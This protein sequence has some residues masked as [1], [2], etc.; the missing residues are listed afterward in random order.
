MKKKEN[1]HLAEGE[2]T[3]HYHAAA[4]K[5][6]VVFEEVFGDNSLQLNAPQGSEVTHQEHKTI[7]LPAGT[8]R[9]GQVLEYDPA[10]EE[11]REVR[12]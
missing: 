10:E 5:E 2:V 12:D 11:A 7:V 8:Y 4:G 3:G 9:T 6:V 1:N